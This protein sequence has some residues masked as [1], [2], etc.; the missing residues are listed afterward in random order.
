MADREPGDLVQV[1]TTGTIEPLERGATRALSAREGIFRVLHSPPGVI[2]MRGVEPESTGPIR[3]AG[4]IGA[5]GAVCDVFAMLAQAG[6]RGQLVLCDSG[7]IRSLFFDKG[8]VLGAQTSVEDE[9]LGA[10]MYRYGVLSEQDLT[11][12]AET[13]T[14]GGRFGE[15]ALELELSS[16]RNVF[17]CLRHQIEEIAFAAFAQ[18]SGTFCFLE[19]FDPT[20]L[21]SHHVISAQALV[22]DGVTRMDEIRYFREKIPSSQYVPAAVNASG[23]A[24]AEYRDTY[25]MIDGR[26]SVEELGR[27]TGRG[28]FAVTKDVYGLERSGHVLIQAPP[29]ADGVMAVAELAN[30]LLR[31][32]HAEAD[33]AN[34]G[35]ELRKGLASFAGGGSG[36]YAVLLLMAGP[37]PDG[38]I[39]A[40]RVAL[41]LQHLPSDT[42]IPSVRRMLYEYVSFAI[43]CV[44]AAAGRQREAGL[45]SRLAPELDQLKP[46]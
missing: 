28:E 18:A 13:A 31:A 14:G 45:S 11:R 1:H 15:V 39:D 19:G 9:R 34:K 36:S 38:A 6:W 10:V 12:V 3:L 20:K 43:F 8:N 23:A 22:M 5:P 16:Q 27:L 17:R 2:L 26:R 24:P 33:A 37:T 30:R 42:T 46:R 44:G 40:S 7:A 32:I 25:Q 35:R 4:E 29:Q 41:N 21:V